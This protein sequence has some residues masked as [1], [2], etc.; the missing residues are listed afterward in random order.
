MWFLPWQ[1]WL[2]FIAENPWATDAFEWL[3]Y[4]KG[5]WSQYESIIIVIALWLVARKLGRERGRL[6]ERVDTLAQHVKAATDASDTAIAAAKEASDTIVAAIATSGGRAAQA[7]GAQAPNVVPQPEASDYANWERISDI[8][9]DLKDRIEL[10]IQ[11]ISHKRVRGKYSQ[12]A[13]RTYR[14]VINALQ[15]DRLLKPG[16][17]IRLLEMDHQYQVLKF[18]PRNVTAEQVEKFVEGLQIINANRALPHLPTEPAEAA[19]AA[20][21]QQ[22]QVVALPEEVTVIRSGAR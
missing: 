8:W 22:D 4:A 20:A 10:K 14:D 5:L 16:V 15:E 9:N 18:R 19:S 3:R 21:D 2:D 7:N 11:E 17:A 12:M 13:R 6:Q 1:S